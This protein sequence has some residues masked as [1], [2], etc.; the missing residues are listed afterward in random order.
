M[1]AGAI[2]YCPERVPNNEIKLS[3][4][5]IKQKLTSLKN[6]MSR[7]QQEYFHFHYSVDSRAGMTEEQARENFYNLQT[8]Y[9]QANQ[10][11]KSL[12]GLKQV[13]PS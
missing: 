8:Q 12:N 13:L 5:K 7:M 3:V 10:E 1:T 9:R 11:M 4:E 2:T 6:Q